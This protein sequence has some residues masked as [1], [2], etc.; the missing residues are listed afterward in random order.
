MERIKDTESGIDQ[1]YC[2]QLHSETL[3]LVAAPTSSVLIA[4]AWSCTTRDMLCLAPGSLLNRVCRSVLLVARSVIIINFKARSWPHIEGC[5]ARGMRC[6]WPMVSAFF[7]YFNRIQRMQSLD[8]TAVVSFLFG[9]ANEIKT[10]ITSNWVVS[11][12]MHR[13]HYI[14]LSKQTT[15]SMCQ[16]QFII[17]TIY[18]WFCGTLK[19]TIAHAIRRQ[20][21]AAK[22]MLLERVK[23]CRRF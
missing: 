11:H 10:S 4:D 19:I 1:R 8:L 5:A 3:K 23:S 22:Q 18:G 6:C 20:M 17:L 7:T 2:I 13:M 15:T 9:C 14:S 12:V 21:L 16:V